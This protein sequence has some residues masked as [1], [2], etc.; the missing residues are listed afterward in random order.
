MVHLGLGPFLSKIA[1]KNLNRF[2]IKVNQTFG[3]LPGPKI[4]FY[5]QDY[6]ILG[7]RVSLDKTNLDLLR[8]ISAQLLY[9]YAVKPDLLYSNIVNC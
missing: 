7:L 5:P 9:R 1:K 4:A 2:T 3:V 6:P 8:I